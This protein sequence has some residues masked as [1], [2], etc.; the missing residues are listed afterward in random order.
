MVL[1]ILHPS[2]IKWQFF[3]LHIL[4]LYLL[5]LSHVE[6][7]FFIPHKKR[8]FLVPRL[9][10]THILTWKQKSCI[11]HASQT[12]EAKSKIT[13]KKEKTSLTFLSSLSY[14]PGQK[15][16]SG[17][18]YLWLLCWWCYYGS[19]QLLVKFHQNSTPHSIC[20]VESDFSFSFCKKKW[21]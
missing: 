4:A 14:F 6:W 7:W 13:K 2:H 12:L 9:T 10:S 19:S 18:G 17:H 16:D 1:Y 20:L 11:L 5:C 21:T 8:T 3:I 15:Y